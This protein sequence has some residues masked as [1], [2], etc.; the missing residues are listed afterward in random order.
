M[1]QTPKSLYANYK[2]ISS[3]LRLI[4]EAA[5][6]GTFAGFFGHKLWFF[7]VFAHFRP[8]YI[9]IFGLLFLWAAYRRSFTAMAVVLALILVNATVLFQF[10]ERMPHVDL[11]MPAASGTSLKVVSANIYSSPASPSL[12]QNY[13]LNTYIDIAILTEYSND[14]DGIFQR[15][16][17]PFAY[18]VKQPQPDNFG[19]ALLSRWPLINIRIVKMGQDVPM[20]SIFATAITP[21]G[22]IRI[23]ATHPAPPISPL[24]ARWNTATV[25]QIIEIL[26]VATIPVLVAGDFNSTPWAYPLNQIINMPHVKGGSFYG[27]WPGFMQKLGLPIDHIFITGP[28]QFTQYRNGPEIGSDHLPLEAVIVR[29]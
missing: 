17:L 16:N 10:H 25:L 8:H 6:F 13:L 7:N 9:V 23:V 11:N 29:Q 5:A 21:L 22:R 12:L 3:D 14:W 18:M 4:I 2:K 27:T 1:T 26:K 19:I 28:Y 24:L 20:P 15:W